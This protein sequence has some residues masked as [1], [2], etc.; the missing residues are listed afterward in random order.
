MLLTLTGCGPN[1]GLLPGALDPR[2]TKS[3]SDE[4]N[5]LVSVSLGASAEGSDRA[6]VVEGSGTLFH[7]RP[8]Q[9]TPPGTNEGAGGLRFRDADIRAVADAVL[10]NIIGAPYVVDP[11][12][13]GNISF[14][15]AGSLSKEQLLIAFEEALRVKEFALVPRAQGFDIVAAQRAPRIAALRAQPVPASATAP[16]FSVVVLVPKHLS[17]TALENILK[18]FAPPGGVLKADDQRSLLILAGTSQELKIMLQTVETFDVDWM[19]GMSVAF[20]K[21]RYVP[22]DELT[23]ELRDI[24]VKAGDPLAGTVRLVPITRINQV[25]AVSAD[26]NKLKE[27]EAWIHRLDVQEAGDGRRMYVYQARN[28]RAED[29]AKS[30]NYIVTGEGTGS[31]GQSQASPSR[32]ASSAGSSSSRNSETRGSFDSLRV[33]ASQEN[34]SLLILA[35][36]SEYAIVE[37]AL[38]Q[39]D[40]PP[41]QVLI[42]ASLAEVSLTDSLRFGVQWSAEVGDSLITFSLDERGGAG[43][44]FP[45]VSVLYTGNADVRGVLNALEGVTEINVISSP[46]LLVL[47]NE[48]AQLQVGD[49][50]PVPRQQAASVQDSN[51]P[52]VNTIDYRSTGVILSVKPRINDGGM[53]F[54]DITQEVSDVAENISSG[55]DAPIIQQRKMSSTIAVKD[56][57]TIVLGGLIRSNNTVSKTGIPLLGKIPLLGA[58]F[59]DNNITKRKTELIVLLSPRIMADAS[60]ITDVMRDLRLQFRQVFGDTPKP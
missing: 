38:E 25:F 42:E 28:G 37:S 24:L 5:K 47:N 30:I 3:A 19:K 46:K 29:L 45:G 22:S 8:P 12:V 41:R 55:I 11:A 52:I 10:G 44:A 53:V 34:N 27:I 21:L 4:K 26:P 50:I 6:E 13:Q 32:A 31:N 15:T 36:P 33:M 1:R 20:F 43:S 57:Q 18:S 56:G 39:L 60:E 51:A 49:E 54:L 40:R 9:A 7:E 35:T 2:P 48:T 14:E 16:G 58:L 17:P 23:E 59:R